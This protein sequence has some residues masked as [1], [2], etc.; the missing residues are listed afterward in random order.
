[1][2]RLHETVLT[3]LAPDAAF[4][5]VADFANNP[6]WDPNT[7]RAE[8][9]D[10]GP[11]G[12]GARYRLD[13]KMRGGTV[14]MEYRVTVW[15]PSSRVVLEGKGDTVVATDEIRFTPDGD[16]TRIDYI[17]D[18]RLTGWMRLLEPLAGGAFDRIAKN[19]A[20]G[21]HRELETLTEAAA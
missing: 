2:P 1:M 10:S 14:P 9:L 21:M 4:A 5:F 15:E 20:A 18:I 12:V 11:L 6:A 3:R 16:G 13:V 19:A 7:E 8:R 17:A